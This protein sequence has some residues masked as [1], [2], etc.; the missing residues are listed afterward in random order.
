MYQLKVY[1]QPSARESAIVGMHGDRL[2]IKIKAPPVDGEANEELRRL[3][4]E[5]FGIAKS[6]VRILRGETSRNKDLE[7]EISPDVAGE[8][9]KLT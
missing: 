1:I 5:L 9:L 2:K 4:G 7:I 8:K 6:K 3:M